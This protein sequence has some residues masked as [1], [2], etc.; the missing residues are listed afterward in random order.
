MKQKI[1]DS[2]L[3]VRSMTQQCVKSAQE[4][5]A[6]WKWCESN[7]FLNK[8]RA[9]QT[10]VTNPWNCRLLLYCV[11]TFW[12][13]PE[14][15]FQ[16]QDRAVCANKNSPLLWTQC[17]HTQLQRPPRLLSRQEQYLLEHLHPRVQPHTNGANCPSMC[18]Q[19]STSKSFPMRKLWSWTH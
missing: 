13:F 18:L 5:L 3:K 15:S 10:C 8:P 2:L 1:W 14:Q 11:A 17:T 16:P 12:N 6:T 9:N 4:R 7:A 19:N